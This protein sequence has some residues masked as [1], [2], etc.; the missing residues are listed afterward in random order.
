MRI[1]IPAELPVTNPPIPTR[2][3]PSRQLR[4]LRKPGPSAGMLRHKFSTVP[5]NLQKTRPLHERTNKLRSAGLR[6]NLRHNTDFASPAATPPTPTEPK[7]FVPNASV[8]TGPYRPI[9]RWLPVGNGFVSPF[10]SPLG[11]PPHTPSFRPKPSPAFSPPDIAYAIVN[12]PFLD[13][14]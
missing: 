5:R 1:P 4:S 3:A 9:R 14:P 10:F 8:Q 6:H 11:G 7:K 13:S 12:P 2:M